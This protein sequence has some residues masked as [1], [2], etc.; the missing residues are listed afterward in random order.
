LLKSLTFEVACRLMVRMSSSAGLLDGFKAIVIF[1]KLLNKKGWALL[2]LYWGLAIAAV[3]GFAALVMV[4]KPAL[5]EAFLDY[6]FPEHFKIAGRMMVEKLFGQLGSLL[7]ANFIVVGGM[8]VLSFL[9]SAVK[10]TLSRHIERENPLGA[11]A[12]SP[13]PIW[14]QALEELKFAALYLLAYNVIFW[15]GYPPSSFCRTTATVLSYIAL[16]V[17]FDITF[18]CPLLLRH[19]IGYGRM[20]RAFFRKPVQSFSFA[21]VWCL[22]V[23]IATQFMTGEK[24]ALAVSV[25][26][27]CH[28]LVVAPAAAGG[29]FLSAKLLPVARDLRPA[30][31]FLSALAWILMLAV[32][33]AS[34]T[35]FFRLADSVNKKSQILKCQYSVDF[36]S[37]DY[38]LPSLLDPSVGISFDVTI[39][40]P[41]ETDV[42]MEQSRLEIKN[43]GKKFADAWLDPIS[44]KAGETAK[45]KVSLKLDVKLSGLKDVKGLFTKPWDFVLWAQVLEGYEFPIYFR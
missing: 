13:W 15:I 45:Q 2:L 27:L 14:R 17:F 34:G 36:R 41:T 24:M 21:V 32:L 38:R 8:S 23:L 16:F 10:E 42:E 19:R 26:L 35:V 22:P 25:L 40:N 12:F 20:V 1:P 37:F 9:C 6:V 29:T 18:L 39:Q 30:P 5:K 11:G 44:V 43:G 31:G 33:G 28:V 4:L 7:I 3:S